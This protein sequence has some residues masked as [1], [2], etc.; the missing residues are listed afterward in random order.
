[1]GSAIPPESEVPH[2]HEPAPRERYE[3]PAAQMVLRGVMMTGA[4]ALA[5]F[6]T[7]KAVRAGLP[8]IAF[9]PLFATAAALLGWAGV[10]HLGGGEKFDDHPWV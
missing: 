9:A 3:P 1:M 10:I 5:A 7:F 4:S 8:G 6:G 2:G